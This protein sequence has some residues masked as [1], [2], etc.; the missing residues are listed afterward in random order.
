MIPVETKAIS[1]RI[2]HRKVAF[3]SSFSTFFL[4]TEKI[5]LATIKVMPMIFNRSIVSFQKIAPERVGIIVESEVSTVVYAH[6]P[7]FNAD[8]L[9]TVD[10]N[11][12]TPK[13]MLMRRV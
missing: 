11:V 13:A 3:F 4:K 5:K 9:N 1:V 7:I 10:N 8:K 2:N 6:G 12:A